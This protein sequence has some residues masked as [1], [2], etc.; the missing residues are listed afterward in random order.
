MSD[1][2]LLAS[3]RVR[4]LRAKA[5]QSPVQLGRLVKEAHRDRTRAIR[6]HSKG[7]TVVVMTWAKYEGLVE[8]L[9]LLRLK[10]D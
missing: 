10:A 3:K 6:L 5:V 7:K 1:A 8:T 9:D 2:K 4:S